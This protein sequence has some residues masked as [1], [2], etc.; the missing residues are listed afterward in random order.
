MT[1]EEVT[2]TLE[3]TLVLVGK[4]LND[5]TYTRRKKILMH[6]SKDKEQGRK[7]LKKNAPILEKSTILILQ[8]WMMSEVWILKLLNNC[9][10]KL[11]YTNVRQEGWLMQNVYYFSSSWITLKH[12]TFEKRHSHELYLVHFIQF[13]LF[14]G[15]LLILS[16][17]FVCL[18][19]RFCPIPPP[20][21]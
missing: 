14:I 1:P 4:T 17:Y 8:N 19:E 10:K 15:Q 13:F 20:G 5:V 3:K 6:F 11:T 18:K 16:N 7:T 12:E 9:L 2:G 21:K